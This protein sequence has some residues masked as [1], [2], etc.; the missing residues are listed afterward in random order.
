MMF[1]KAKM[2]RKKKAREAWRLE[3][4]RNDKVVGGF[5]NR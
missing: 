4:I 2:A 5:N 3:S 1:R